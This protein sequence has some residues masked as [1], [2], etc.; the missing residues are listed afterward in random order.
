MA[1]KKKAESTAT[2]NVAE[3][4]VESAPV[5]KTYKAKRTLDPHQYVTVRSGFHGV[6]VYV[7]SKTGEKFKWESFGDEQ[8]MELQ[9][10]KN[11]KNS[12]KIYFEGSY[13][14]LDDPEVIE[15][16][17][18]ERYYKHALNYKEFETIFDMPADEL[19]E[20]LKDVPKDQKL[21]I[22]YRAKQLIDEGRIDSL[23]VITVLEKHLG[24]ELVER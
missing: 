2:T 8:D 4:V 23:K 22:A 12:H 5:R 7:S 24:V 10:L 14:L 21:T 11:A 20:R 19:D 13:F 16:L 1:T 6:L 15:Y 18:V 9:E 3:P 17:G